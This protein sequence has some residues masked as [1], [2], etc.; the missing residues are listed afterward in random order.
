MGKLFAE[1]VCLLGLAA[2][3][4][5]ANL[6]QPPQWV[7]SHAS[8]ENCAY[9]DSQSGDP[10]YQGKRT[11]S[12]SANATFSVSDSNALLAITLQF[13]DVV[14]GSF[15]WP[16]TM[17]QPES[18]FYGNLTK[19]SYPFGP[20]QMSWTSYSCV[21]CYSCNSTG[22][23]AIDNISYTNQS[24][25]AIDLRF[26]YQ[27]N[28]TAA[29]LSGFL[30]WDMA[31]VAYPP[32][33]VAPPGG[34]WQ[35][36]QTA[37]PSSGNYV[38]LE[39]QPGDVLGGGQNY[40]YLSSDAQLS[41]NFIGGY[42]SYTSSLSVQVN[43]WTTTYG[44]F[45]LMAGVNRL[46]KGYYAN[47]LPYNYVLSAISWGGP[48]GWCSYEVKPS[49]WF[50]VDEVS[51][52]GSD[53]TVVKLRF[54]IRCTAETSALHG[55]LNWAANNPLNPPLPVYPS[56]TNLWQPPKSAI[57]HTGNY[58]YVEGET[59][60]VV[61]GPLNVTT[62]PTDTYFSLKWVPYLHSVILN[63]TNNY[64]TQLQ[65][66][67]VYTMKRLEKG[68]YADIR[69]PFGNP[70]VGRV[71]LTIANCSYSSYTGWLSVDHIVHA[72]EEVTELSARFELKC[73]STLRVAVG[74]K[75]A[76]R[77]GP[78]PVFPPPHSL[79]Q[80]VPSVLPASATYVYLQIQAGYLSL[81]AAN[82]TYTA[83]TVQV[84]GN[85]L[86][87]TIQSNEGWNGYFTACY[88]M[89]QLESGYY[90]GLG[91]NYALGSLYWTSNNSPWCMTEGWFVL[92]KVEREG[93]TVKAV[94]MRF[95]QHCQGKT[96]VLSAA[97]KWRAATASLASY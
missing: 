36:P 53:L 47:Q 34:L 82:Y 84:S 71:G 9:L 22:W 20:N 6:W 90:G 39:S 26:Q 59:G 37:I 41:L 13:L 73:Q 52:T 51:Y 15:I 92:D 29:P 93:E 14:S 61:Q 19:Y 42:S 79:W 94:E 83:A 4:S 70:A 24:I 25:S 32:G 86:Q 31:R 16:A 66:Q 58:A 76:N 3:T 97:V 65:L 54:E 88:G 35:P 69:P 89:K 10:V 33:P 72:G 60:A 30:S 43:G 48:M 7:L 18:G 27:C 50:V 5:P 91:N 38:Y 17:S 81:P 67:P 1:F 95:Q 64:W 63:L 75:A 68:Y 40:T 80:P 55:A 49:G 78:R 74:W 96:P 2:C 28:S 23:L 57:P 8:S 77:A 62:T 44:S 12:T 46:E 45:Q 87:L 85:T 11:F 21:G 56:P